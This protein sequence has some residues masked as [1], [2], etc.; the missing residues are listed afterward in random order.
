MVL[1][2]SLRHWTDSRK[3]ERKRAASRVVS[4]EKKEVGVKQIAPVM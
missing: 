3:T 4:P 1:F 2:R